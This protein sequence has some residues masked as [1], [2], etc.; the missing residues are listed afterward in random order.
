M[1]AAKRQTNRKIIHHLDIGHG[2]GEYI[3]SLARQNPKKKYM[4]IEWERVEREKPLARMHN[5]KL[6]SGD[7][8]NRLTRLPAE[9]VE[10]I[11]A[12]FF[13]SGYREMGV[14]LHGSK[15]ETLEILLKREILKQAKRVLV[16]GGKFELIEYSWGA[17]AFKLQLE[18]MGFKCDIMTLPDAD[19]RKTKTLKL[20]EGKLKKHPERKSELSTTKIVAI[21]K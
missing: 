1:L 6:L 2:R 17:F 14:N 4:G 8:L 13:F 3:S 10:N 7:V 16:S 12:N 15:G 19:K 9:S 18:E 5:L 20:I 11:T 21:K